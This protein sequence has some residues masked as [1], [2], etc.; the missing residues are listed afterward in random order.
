MNPYVPSSQAIKEIAEKHIFVLDNF[1]GYKGPPYFRGK[2]IVLIPSL[3]DRRY[4]KPIHA[5]DDLEDFNPREDEILFFNGV[6]KLEPK[7]KKEKKIEEGTTWPTYH[8]RLIGNF[9]GESI[10]VFF[11]TQ[12]ES[13]INQ[14]LEE[15]NNPLFIIA[16]YDKSRESFGILEYGKA[17][18]E[19][20]KNSTPEP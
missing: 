2:K 6:E 9:N 12:N 1:L 4:G 19:R 7:R 13:R 15:K 10:D 20:D 18:K 5:L 8:S 3:L 16:K 17:I 11:R 14:F